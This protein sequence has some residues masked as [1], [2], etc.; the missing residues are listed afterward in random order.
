MQIRLEILHGSSSQS[1]GEAGGA[2]EFDRRGSYISRTDVN[3]EL[4]ARGLHV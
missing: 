3:V 2:A 1:D 4:K